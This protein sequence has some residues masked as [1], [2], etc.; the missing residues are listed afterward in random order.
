MKKFAKQRRQVN[1]LAKNQTKST[2]LSVK[3][4]CN[5]SIKRIIKDKSLSTAVK[6]VLIRSN[7][8]CKIN[9]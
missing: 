9:Y 6:S 8:N 5:E 3:Q 7:E 2:R 4:F 1:R